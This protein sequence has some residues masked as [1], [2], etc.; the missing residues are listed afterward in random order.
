MQIYRGIFKFNIN[1]AITI[2]DE[3]RKVSHF[4]IK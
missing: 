4:K 1:L 3:N 2:L